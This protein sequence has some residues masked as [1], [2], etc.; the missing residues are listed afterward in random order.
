[1]TFETGKA[2]GT[3]LM[4]LLLLLLGSSFIFGPVAK[5]EE[6]AVIDVHLD[7]PQGPIAYSNRAY[8]DQSLGNSSHSERVSTRRMSRSAW[9]LRRYLVTR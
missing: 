5:G 3:N 2:E 8:I 4:K 9:L 1:M 6:L 7:E